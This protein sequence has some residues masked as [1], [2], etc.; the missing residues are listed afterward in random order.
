MQPKG[1]EDM[2]SLSAFKEIGILLY[3]E[4]KGYLRKKKNPG[5][6]MMIEQ[7]LLLQQI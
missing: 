6:Q 5:L 1:E 3:S 7:L 4:L 2:R